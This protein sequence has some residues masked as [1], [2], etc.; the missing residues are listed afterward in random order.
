MASREQEN[1]L[2]HDFKNKYLWGVR[3]RYIIIFAGVLILVGRIEPRIGLGLI[4][5]LLAYNLIAHLIYVLKKQYQL[6]QIVVLISIFQIFD[7]LT[8]T[9]LIY[10]TG[11]LESPYWFLY[12]VLIVINGFGIYSRYSLVVFLIATF[13]AV[14]YLG[15]LMSAYWGLIPAYGPEFSLPP[16]ELLRSILNRTVFSVASFFL[17]A[18]TIYYFSKALYQNQASL[19]QKNAQLLSAL[20]Q[21]KDIDRMKDDYVSTA[22]HELRTPL[23]V[24]RENVSLIADGVTGDV[25]EKQKKLLGSSLENVDRLSNMLESLLDISRIESRTS[26]LK[27]QQTDVGQLMTKAIRIMDE[28]AEH[29]HIELSADLPTGLSIWIDPDQIIRV[30]INLIDNAIKY[31]PPGGKVTVTVEKSNNEVRTSVSDTGIGIEEKYLPHMFERFMRI[32]HPEA[33]KVKSSGLGLSICKAI[34]EMHG[35]KIW[36]ESKAGAGTRFTFTLPRIESNE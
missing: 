35:G 24:I 11:W 34:I 14:F 13:S 32:E 7:V 15:L 4:F 33:P 31:T 17:F 8:V 26:E 5:F 9:A 1:L 10:M 23:A 36:V 29:K 3:L 30:A 21:L 6:W 22:S 2:I 25:N 16:Q 12:L 18:S 20:E 28:L 27:C 19:T